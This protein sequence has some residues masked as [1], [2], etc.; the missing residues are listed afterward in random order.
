MYLAIQEFVSKV[1]GP[2]YVYKCI[3]H[4]DGYNTYTLLWSSI[5]CLY[6]L[7]FAGNL[8]PSQEAQNLYWR[9]WTLLLGFI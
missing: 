4:L 1:K 5:K 8:L 6:L 7:I 3:I 2:N 9:T